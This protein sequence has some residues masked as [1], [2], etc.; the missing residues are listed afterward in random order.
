METLLNWGVTQSSL[1][2][3]AAVD[4]VATLHTMRGGPTQPAAPP[5]PRSC[6]DAARPVDGR[7]P[8]LAQDGA[9][10]VI[11]IYLRV[12]GQLK[13]EAR[14]AVL[15]TVANLALAAAQFADPLLFGRIVDLMTRA[16]GAGRALSWSELLPLLFAWAAFGVFS[17]VAAMLIGLHA[18]RLA[19]RNRLVVMAR[20]FEHVLN[21]PLSY[22]SASHSGRLLKAMLDGASAMWAM[23][24]SFFREN[25]SSFIA[26]FV[27]LP[28]TVF[29]NWRLASLL[30]LLV[31]V[32]YLVANFVVRRTVALQASVDR[33]NSSLAEHAADALGNIPVIQSFTRIENESQ[34]LRRIIQ[35]LLAA[36]IPVL[37]WWAVVVVASRASATLTLLAI[38]VL[39]AWLN[40]R[41]LATIGE[42]V[43]FMNF[44]TMMIGR[45]EQVVGFVNMLFQQAGKIREFFDVLD[46]R[47]AVADRAGASDAGR[48]IGAVSFEDV[49][50]SYDCKRQ[51][52]RNVSFVAKPGETIALVGS[53]GSGKSTTLGLLHRVFDPDSGRVLVDGTDIRDFTLVSLRRN[54]G[55]VFQEP[56]LFARSI[57]EN[58]RIGKPDATPEEIARALD[59]AQ[60]SEFVAR[61][62]DGTATRVGERGRSLS[63]GERQRLSIARA[64]LKD[65]P[66][67][68]FD[69]ATSALDATTERQIQ[70]ALE[71]ATKGRT[72]FVIAHRLATVRNADRIL[73]FDQGEIVET[74]SFDELVARG[75]RFATLAAA[76][77]MAGAE[78]APAPLENVAREATTA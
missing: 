11:R 58:L 40:S 44:A 74:G 71:A 1:R 38:F 65:P 4:R 22:H 77:F 59:L 15:L 70:K 54:I 62:S 28:A 18:D 43:A 27:L 51:A 57:D 9:V 17:I 31:G 60:A 47:A 20:F 56:M 63:G 33:Y 29:V 6:L 12:L 13:D 23:W 78:A 68:V 19:H 16:Q 64:L 7:T 41:G 24:L 73:V 52:V 32:F 53:T 67:M 50:Y 69:E 34:S 75:G 36:Q 2:L 25:C 5:D 10:L 48:L 72:T 3:G 21:L 8:L 26:L 76:Q 37:S 39:G 55:V 30:I 61:Q 42:I 45:L 14:L 46:T 49:T 66:I 35:D